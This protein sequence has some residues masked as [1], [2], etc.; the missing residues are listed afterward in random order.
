MLVLILWK[1]KKGFKQ[2]ELLTSKTSLFNFKLNI[3]SEY[4][5]YIATDESSMEILDMKLMLWLGI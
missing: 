2:Y 1:D 4:E 3:A 5:V